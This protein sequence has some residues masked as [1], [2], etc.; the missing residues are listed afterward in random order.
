M[1]KG[2]VIATAI[3]TSASA[4]AAPIR[5]TALIRRIKVA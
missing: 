2:A 5:M 4:S 3:K 1:G